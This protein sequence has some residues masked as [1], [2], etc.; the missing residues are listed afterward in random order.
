MQYWLKNLSYRSRVLEVGCGVGRIG[1]YIREFR[2]DLMLIGIDFSDGMLEV[3]LRSGVY[4][5]LIKADIVE[6]PIR[7]SSIDLVFAMDI[8]FHIVRPSRKGK[9]WSEM[10]R[11]AK[12]EEGVAAYSTGHELTSLIVIEKLMKFLLPNRWVS[13]RIRDKIIIW[14][15]IIC[16]KYQ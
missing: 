7:S 10:V 11:V 9:A 1:K 6:I 14:L 5:S 2:P 13:S 8:L 15:T 12:T 16:D 3:A 4:T